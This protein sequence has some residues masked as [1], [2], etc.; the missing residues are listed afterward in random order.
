MDEFYSAWCNLELHYFIENSKL[1]RTGRTIR[2]I[3]S[4][5][6]LRWFNVVL[7]N[8]KVSKWIISAIYG[9]SW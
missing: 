6:A 7:G 2:L 5:G 1:C 9:R 4:H 3:K 8:S